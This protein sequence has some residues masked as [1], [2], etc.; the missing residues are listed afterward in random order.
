MFL[1][2]YNKY[3]VLFLMIVIVL[4]GV[5]LR[6]T[7]IDQTVVAHPIRADAE[8][9]FLCAANLKMFGVYSH[10]QAAFNGHP[11]ELKPDALVT[12]GFPLFLYPFIKGKDKPL[13]KI[14]YFLLTQALLGAL[15]IILTYLIFK[16]LGPV[17]ALGA[18]LMT[19]ISPHLVSI[20]T[21]LLTETLFCF[22][23]LAFLVLASRLQNKNC[24]LVW[25]LFTGV[26]LGLA[27]LTRPWIQGFI[28]VLLLFLI[29]HFRSMKFLK[30]GAIIALGF[31]LVI[32]PWVARNAISLG[33]VTDPSLTLYSVYHGWYPDMMYD[34]RLET[35]GIAY[36]F[37]PWTTQ[38]QID[39]ETIFQELSHRIKEK[40]AEYFKWYFLGKIQT[41]F[42]W[43]I[44]GG[45]G[46]I[47][48]YPLL[49]TPYT[50]EPLFQTTRTAMLLV[51]P[52]F[53][54]LAL[55]GVVIAWLPG[56]KRDLP[57]SFIWTFQLLSLLMIYFIV[58]HIIGAPYPR[59]SIPLRP[60]IYGM[61]L[62]VLFWFI[63]YVKR[64]FTH[65]RL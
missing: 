36:H 43:S 13:L 41:V 37:D 48:V 8:K 6:Y 31:A 49:K 15:C 52:I 54:A 46:D 3:T 34:N 22:F 24:R 64:C 32:G 63:T 26:L 20:G 39:R 60:V 56:V 2:I 44:L 42:S 58:L 1:N 59:Y 9:Y 40:P 12:P 62:S 55:L 11:E 57:D 17:W 28:I 5:F 53:V 16:K 35:K 21:Y 45:V 19:A 23:L 4:L 33:M 47:F 61:A 50:T 10:S 27:T 65:P 25:Y 7:A 30:R 14:R 18:A 29:A 38:R 51:H